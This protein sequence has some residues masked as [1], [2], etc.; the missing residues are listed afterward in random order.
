MSEK[1][2]TALSIATLGLFLVID[3]SAALHGETVI[4]ESQRERPGNRM[5]QTTLG[6]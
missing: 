6:H 4:W 2:S 5:V 3:V 1:S